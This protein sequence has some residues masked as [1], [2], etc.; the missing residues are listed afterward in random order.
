MHFC[1]YSYL[2]QCTLLLNP[3]KLIGQANIYFYPSRCLHS[4]PL[5][6]QP[7]LPQLMWAMPPLL[8]HMPPLLLH[9]PQHLPH[10]TQ[11]QLHTMRRRFPHNHLPTSMEELMSTADTLPRLRLRMNMELSR[12]SKENIAFLIQ[13]FNIDP[14]N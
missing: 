6:L 5:L 3:L 7:W 4:L 11:L 14:F 10:T 1:I 8:L 2:M 12:V 13:I 9:M